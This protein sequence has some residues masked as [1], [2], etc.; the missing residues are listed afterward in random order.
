MPSRESYRDER[1]RFL[2]SADVEARRASGGLLGRIFRAFSGELVEEEP[3]YTPGSPAAPEEYRFFP[4]WTET[5]Q[6]ETIVWTT[7]DPGTPMDP[8]AI[9]ASEFPEGYTSFQV[10]F[11][12]PSNPTY[13]R[14]Y[15]SYE[16]LYSTEWPP[17]P[18][19]GK[20]LGATGIGAIVFYR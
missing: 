12:V 20:R 15:A 17:S 2:R 19:W 16:T 5:P 4:N 18:S 8:D 1:G 13:P 14:G 10:R 6:H 3:A 7:G 9:L 11:S